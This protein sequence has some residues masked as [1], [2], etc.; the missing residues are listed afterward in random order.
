MK[1]VP[2]VI[3]AQEGAQTPTVDEARRKTRPFMTDDFHYRFQKFHPNISQQQ[4][5]ERYDSTPMYEAPYNDFSISG[6]LLRTPFGTSAFYTGVANKDQ[7]SRA[8]VNLR[9]AQVRKDPEVIQYAQF[10]RNAINPNR[11][12]ITFDSSEP[13]DQHLYDTMAHE[14]R[15]MYDYEVEGLCQDE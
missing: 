7:S 11:G 4:L 1:V 2:K 15:H 12:T 14:T 10:V 8:D 6:S 9:R 5:E 13:Y 3:K